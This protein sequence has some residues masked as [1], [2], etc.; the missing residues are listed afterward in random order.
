MTSSPLQIAGDF[1]GTITTIPARFLYRSGNGGWELC[2][3]TALR[4]SA[5]QR[6]ADTS[7]PTLIVFRS[8]NLV[9]R[10][11]RQSPFEKPDTYRPP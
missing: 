11:L 6:L 8:S 7:F 10:L 2:D 1:F 5:D 4:L 3:F 9:R